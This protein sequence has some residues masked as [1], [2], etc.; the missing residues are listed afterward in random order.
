MKKIILSLAFVIGL[1]STQVFAQQTSFGVKAEA[2]VSNFRVS[3]MPNTKGKLGVGAGIGGFA[4]VDLSNWFALQPEVMFS[5]QNSKLEQSGL[6][7]NIRS[8]NVEVPV[9]A[10]FQLP[11]ADKSRAYIGIGPYGRFGFS[12]K[13]RTTGI[14]LYKEYNGAKSDLQRFDAGLAATV[15]YE[16]SNGIQINASYKFGLLDQLNANKKIA[17]LKNQKISLGLG[18]RF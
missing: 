11:A 10:M 13:D 1:G 12:A 3:D 15:G 5:L 6:K 17:S 18:Y 14:N 7:H 16:F 2:N 8:F 9:Y 4:K